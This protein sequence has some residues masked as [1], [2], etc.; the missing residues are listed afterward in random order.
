[1]LM[2]ADARGRIGQLNESI[3]IDVLPCRDK[4]GSEF[5][6]RIRIS[7]LMSRPNTLLI[8]ADQ[9]RADCIGSYSNSVCRTPH[10]DKLAQSGMRLEQ[11]YTPIVVCSL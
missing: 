6:S 1:M 8:T 7:C 10:I 9:L 5:P 4:M 2:G 3:Q 11:A